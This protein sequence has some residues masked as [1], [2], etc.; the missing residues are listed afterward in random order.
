MHPLSLLSLSL[1]ILCVCVCVYI[2]IYIYIYTHTF[3]L[4][5]VHK[6]K[7]PVYRSGKAALAGTQTGRSHDTHVH[8]A[9]FVAL[10]GIKCMRDRARI[11]KILQSM[12]WHRFKLLRCMFVGR[13]LLMIP[14]TYVLPIHGHVPNAHS[15]DHAWNMRL[16]TSIHTCGT[17]MH[18]NARMH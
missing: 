13:L 3:L 10:T 8:V 12:Q 17:S 4:A 18:D 1:S 11:C 5:G 6:C 16:M 15:L 9:F 14:N 7:V 2:Y